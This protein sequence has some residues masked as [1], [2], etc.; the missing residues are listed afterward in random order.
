MVFWQIS[1]QIRSI[2]YC[3][4]S[5]RKSYKYLIIPFSYRDSASTPQ[6]AWGKR[7]LGTISWLGRP[8]RLLVAEGAGTNTCLLPLPR[9]ALDPGP[10]SGR[11]V[12]APEPGPL[13]SR[14]AAHSP[15][16]RLQVFL[17][18]PRRESWV[19][20]PAPRR[21]RPSRRPSPGCGLRRG[22]RS[23]PRAG[24]TGF[25]AG[26]PGPPAPGRLSGRGPG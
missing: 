13:A 17:R 18:A 26:G 10:P 3:G 19:L 7:D 23:F 6:D 1:D 24:P 21:S 4:A 5:C 8:G 11:R 22:G 15:A 9:A 16:A 20:G 2:F 25:G 12:R 14:G